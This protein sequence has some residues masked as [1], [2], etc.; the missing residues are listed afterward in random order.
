V[1]VKPAMLLRDRRSGATQGL[2]AEAGRRKDMAKKESW[3]EREARERK[4][5][6]VGLRTACLVLGRLGVEAVEVEFDGSGDEGFLTGVRYRPEPP[7]GI[8]E[9]LEHL[10]RTFVYRELPG[11]WEINE[12]SYGTVRIDVST[13]TAGTNQ[14]W[15]E[16]EEADEDF[17]S[18][19]E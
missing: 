9:G 17:D 14:H 2:L 15:R 13:A 8:P 4:E 19:M 16:P 5:A 6:E 1:N 12:G 18:D 3:Q 11:G 10:V 7:A